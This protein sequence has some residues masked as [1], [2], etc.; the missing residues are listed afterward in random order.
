MPD[1]EWYMHNVKGLIN[2]CNE[3]INDDYKCYLIR[4]L[5]PNL[6][7]S[8]PRLIRSKVNARFVNKVHEVI[9]T[10]KYKKLA[11][12][13]YFELGASRQ[14]IEKSRQRWERDLKILL[15]EYEENPKDPRIVFY[16]AQ[17]YECL[18]DF[19]NAYK[20]YEIRSKQ[21]GWTEENFETF[22]R[23]GRVTDYLSTKDKNYSWHMAQD[24]Y[25]NAC[26]IMPHRAEP[27]LRLA[28]HYWPDGASPI[29]VAL[30]YTFAKRAY[31]LPYPEKDLL[32]ID[33]SAYN[34]RRYELLS[35]SAYHVGDFELGELAT[36]KALQVKEM[37]YLL[38]NLACYME[39]NNKN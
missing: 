8:V 32:F 7:F 11:D 22:Y 38:R 17:T 23:L 31:E 26:K 28:E 35:K 39:M 21:E 29:N 15:N 18:A 24:Y 14:G 34:F 19:V 6:D 30:C 33:P 9:V 13:I 1:A 36:R 2:F 25:F 16:L 20:Y 4:I 10:D 37:P 3:N 12:D 5:N 27:F